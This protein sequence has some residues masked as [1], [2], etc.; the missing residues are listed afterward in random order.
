MLFLQRFKIQLSQLATSSRLIPLA[1]VVLV[2]G[3]LP[4]YPDLPGLSCI[5]FPWLC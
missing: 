5:Q 4:L 2:G 1:M 3:A